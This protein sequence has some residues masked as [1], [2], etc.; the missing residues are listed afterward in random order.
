MLEDARSEQR[1]GLHQDFE[2]SF[3]QHPPLPVPEGEVGLS[4][5]SVWPRRPAGL[6]GLVGGDSKGFQEPEDLAYKV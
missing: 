5:L 1:L 2:G 6:W 4:D 3:P